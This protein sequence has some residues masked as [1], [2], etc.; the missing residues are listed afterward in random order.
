MNRTQHI[1]PSL[2]AAGGARKY[3]NLSERA[4][5]LS[6]LVSLPLAERLF[7]LALI[8]TGARISE[9]LSITPQSFQFGTGI[10]AIRTLKR[11][12]HAVREIPIPPELTT[13]LDDCFDLQR[14][15]QDPLLA[16]EPLW[17]FHRVTGWRLI[18]YVMENAGIH[19]IRA[20]PRGLRHAF[21]VGTLAA[22]VPLNVVQRLL[23]H[24]SIKTTTIYTEACGP[25]E[26][27]IVARFWN[28]VPS[29]PLAPHTERLDPA[30]PG[31]PWR[32]PCSHG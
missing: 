30:A 5:L 8:W 13:E 10:L 15:Q 3:V 7:I 27:A 25:D 6:Q 32:Q 26:Q 24:S 12:R 23:G 17:T 16:S 22:G 4:A 28:Y 19:G 20:T 9:V 31:S 29:V 21:G 14:R 1:T 2:Y 18:K 11:R